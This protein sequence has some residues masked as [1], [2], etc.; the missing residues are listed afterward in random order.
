MI[1]IKVHQRESLSQEMLDAVNHS[2]CGRLLK[3]EVQ[4]QLLISIL[5]EILNFLHRLHLRLG[6]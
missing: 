6:H 2:L 5:K 4:P 3:D 1:H